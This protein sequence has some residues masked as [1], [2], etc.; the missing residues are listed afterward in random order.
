MITC[1]A[2][3]CEFISL[4]GDKVT[5][6]EL[7]QPLSDIEEVTSDNGKKMLGSVAAITD[8]HVAECAEFQPVAEG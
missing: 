1:S 2:F 8:T 5:I 4:L 3:F 6:S 7:E